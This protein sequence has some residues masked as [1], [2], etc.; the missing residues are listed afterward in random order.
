MEHPQH[1][2]PGR[3]FHQSGREWYEQC[4]KGSIFEFARWWSIQIMHMHLRAKDELCNRNFEMARVWFVH[5]CILNYAPSLWPELSKCIIT[6]F[7]AIGNDVSSNEHV[8][9]TCNAG[10]QHYAII[11][12]SDFLQHCQPHR[13][14]FL[15]FGYNWSSS[16]DPTG[17]LGPVV[18]SHWLR[19]RSLKSVGCR[20]CNLLLVHSAIITSE[21]NTLQ[22]SILFNPWFNWSSS[23]M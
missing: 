9:R 13:Q 7:S 23:T 15:F 1:T 22:S 18:G 3:V 2:L 17:L 8:L 12:L 14:L 11:C 5:R 20:A 4:E 21:L 10:V 19:S 6:A 16:L